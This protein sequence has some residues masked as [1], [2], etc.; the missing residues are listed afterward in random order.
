MIEFLFML[1]VM[2]LCG[3]LGLY[4]LVSAFGMMLVGS[5]WGGKEVGVVFMFLGAIFLAMAVYAAPFEVTPAIPTDGA[6]Q[7]APG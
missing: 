7:I 1:V 6:Q 3:L 4:F 2:V 5:S